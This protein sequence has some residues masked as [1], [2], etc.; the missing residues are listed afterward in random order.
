MHRGN[1]RIHAAYVSPPAERCHCAHHRHRQ[2]DPPVDAGSAEA[3]RRAP[4]GKSPTGPWQV[5]GGKRPRGRRQ[6]RWRGAGSGERGVGIKMEAAYLS[7]AD[8]APIHVLDD[9]LEFG[10]ARVFEDDDGMLAGIVEEEGLEV[11][12]AGREDH[13]VGLDG[14]PVGRQRHVHKR[15][16]LEQLVKH[17]RQIRL[18]IVP[19]QT[20]V[21]CC[22]R[23]R[24]RHRRCRRRRRHLRRHGRRRRASLVSLQPEIQYNSQIF[25]NQ[26]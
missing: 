9:G 21:R 17:R 23:C 13:A 11:G 10:P 25:E 1:N 16:V 18:V 20:Q 4:G 22:R 15:L 2:L 14:V 5:A 6:G 19:A 12:R 24:R 26:S 8:L 7:D 3:E